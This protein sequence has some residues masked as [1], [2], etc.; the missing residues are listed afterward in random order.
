[1]A[2][3]LYLLAKRPDDWLLAERGSIIL[4]EVARGPPARHH[5]YLL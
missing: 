1:M 2:R 5:R 3:G 4:S